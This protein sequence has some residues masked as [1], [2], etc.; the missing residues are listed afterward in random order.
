MHLVAFQVLLSII[1][2]LLIPVAYGHGCM[3]LPNPRGALSKGS[4]FVKYPVL[5]S[6][7]SSEDYLLHF[8]AGDRTEQPGAARDSQ[9]KAAGPAGWVPYEPSQPGFVWRAG[10]CGD[11]VTGNDHLKG[12]LYY[13]DGY[14]AATYMQGGVVEIAMGV[15]VHHNGFFEV[16]VCDVSRCPGGD[17]SPDCFLVPG[18]C[19]QLSRA[20][21]D[22]C[23][24]RTST[25][26]APTDPNYPGRWYLPCESAGHPEPRNWFSYGPGTARFRLPKNFKCDHCVLQWY[27]LT[28]NYCNP[29]GVVRFYEGPNAPLTWSA[30]KGQADAFGGYTRLNRPCGAEHDRFPEEYYQCSDIRIVDGPMSSPLPPAS[31]NP[32]FYTPAPTPTETALPYASPEPSSSSVPQ[33]TP[34]TSPI[35]ASM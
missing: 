30:C 16:R 11:T 18:A 21:N 28:A 6:N 9:I 14:I 27:W 26:C 22:I 20:G 29:P 10:V 34:E 8:P 1:L 19:V 17:I 25:R 23:E 7:S 4:K 15:A 24:S 33:V 35:Y 2:A 3:I 32:N 31:F 5:P 13:N 12:G